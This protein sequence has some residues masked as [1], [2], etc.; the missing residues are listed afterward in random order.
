M[1][2]PT[3]IKAARRYNATEEDVARLAQAVKDF[4]HLDWAHTEETISKYIDLLYADDEDEEGV[5]EED[6]EGEEEEVIEEET[7]DGDGEEGNGEIESRVRKKNQVEPLRRSTSTPRPLSARPSRTAE[8]SSPTADG[9]VP[10]RPPHNIG[11]SHHYLESTIEAAVSTNP[12][13]RAGMHRRRKVFLCTLEQLQ[14]I[15]PGVRLGSGRSKRVVESLKNLLDIDEVWGASVKKPPASGTMPRTNS[16]RTPSQHPSSQPSGTAAVKNSTSSLTQPRA[17]ESKLIGTPLYEIR[18]LHLLTSIALLSPS[19]Q[20]ANPDLKSRLIFD[21]IDTDNSGKIHRDDI[22]QTISHSALEN[23]LHLTKAEL[24]A[25]ADALMRRMDIDG[26]GDVEFEEFRKTW[27]DA[28]GLRLDFVEGGKVAEGFLLD[29]RGEGESDEEEDGVGGGGGKVRV[30]GSKMSLRGGWGWIQK[31]RV[32]FSLHKRSV[33]F[34]TLYILLNMMMFFLYLRSVYTTS[35]VEILGWGSA[36]AKAFAGILYLNV[37]LSFLTTSRTLIT[38]LRGLPIAHMIPFDHATFFH[39]IVGYVITAAATGHVI[40]HVAGTFKSA[41]T[42]TDLELVNSIIMG[43]KFER[44]PTYA[45]LFFTT[46]PGLTGLIALLALIVLVTLSIPKIRRT[47]FELFWYSHHAYLIFAIALLIHGTWRWIQFPHMFMYLS[48]PF[49][50]Y[51]TERLLRIY[52]GNFVRYVPTL[53][54]MAERTVKIALK[55][56]R[57]TGNWLPQQRPGQYIYVNFPELSKSQWHPFTVTS[58]PLDDTID[59]YIRSNGN[60]TDELVQRAEHSA[61]LN[62]PTPPWSTTVQID[63]P[64]GAPAEHWTH[65]ENTMLI[66]AGIGVTPFASILRHLELRMDHQNAKSAS[67]HSLHHPSGTRLRRVDFYWVNRTRLA[68]SWFLDLL[69]EIEKEDRMGVVRI[70]TFITGANTR[71]DVRS[72]LLWRGLECVREDEGS[73]GGVEGV[74]ATGVIME[75]EGE[76]RVSEVGKESAGVNSTSE[77]S[78]TTNA[79]ARSPSPTKQ[80]K[81]LL[82]GLTRETHFGRPDWDEIF[83]QTAAEFPGGTVGVFY[84]GPPALA[85]EVW[86][87]CRKMSARRGKERCRFVFRMENF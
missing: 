87:H 18:V 14:E 30:R 36:N 21:M 41:S 72:G 76:G 56:V 13:V 9:K 66:G 42:A 23:A 25:V 6:E 17:V 47:R 74:K 2:T 78:A 68:F 10:Q 27:P 8:S 44:R 85:E 34:G 63:G 77:S 7:E 70:H 3:S 11:D 59:V 37:P 26:S 15:L 32:Y 16:T 60:W 40:G 52:R 62:E 48:L 24:D 38:Y 39:Q 73:G 67:L 4:T 33:I 28:G 80:K 61:R 20:N 83:E 46:L 19:A 29:L 5:D 35:K 43:V 75:D 1:P 79:N 55:P 50:W 69:R 58:S 54:P 84:C 82:T 22:L 71:R 12:L 31:G 64:F 65:F 53:T 49:S 57:G 51:L 86:D 45:S 81:S